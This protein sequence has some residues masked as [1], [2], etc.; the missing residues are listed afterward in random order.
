[1]FT[2]ELAV[3]NAHHRTHTITFEPEEDTS[4]GTVQVWTDE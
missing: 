1:L 4:I 2:W 3:E